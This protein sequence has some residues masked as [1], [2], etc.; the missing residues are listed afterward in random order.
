MS[1]MQASVQGGVCAASFPALLHSQQARTTC[2][3][4]T[5]V[6]ALHHAADHRAAKDASDVAPLA[7]QADCSAVAGRAEGSARA[8]SDGQ[9]AA[10]EVGCVRAAEPGLG[11]A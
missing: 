2:I 1:W 4:L 9:P 7:L 10:R 11:Q 8:E 6:L 5:P 3:R